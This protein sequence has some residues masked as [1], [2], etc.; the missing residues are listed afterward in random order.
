MSRVIASRPDEVE[1]IVTHR[2]WTD[3]QQD[4]PFAGNGRAGEVRR[5]CA[6]IAR[7]EGPFAG[8]LRLCRRDRPHLV[9]G[10]ER[11]AR[12][13]TLTVAQKFA[14]GLGVP[15]WRLFT[16]APEAT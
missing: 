15:L 1:R 9:S 10:I 3:R 5:E 11:G 7:G 14:D 12:N 16:D 8:G 13:P 4:C 2:P 6:A